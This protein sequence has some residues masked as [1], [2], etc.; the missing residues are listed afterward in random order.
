[1]MTEKKVEKRRDK[2]T[3]KLKYKCKACSGE[4]YDKYTYEECELCGGEGYIYRETNSFQ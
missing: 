3:E 1:M 4:G 2:T